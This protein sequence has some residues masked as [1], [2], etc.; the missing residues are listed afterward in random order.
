MGSACYGRLSDDLR[1]KLQFATL[2]TSG[3]YEG[4]KATILNRREGTVDQAVFR[5]SDVLGVKQVSNPNFPK[6]IIPYAWT[7]DG[8]TEWYVYHP[9]QADYKQLGGAVE[10][11][12]SVF[13]A[14]ALEPT[15]ES[16]PTMEDSPELTL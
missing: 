12:C 2:G 4:I 13:Q 14:Q 16:V 1:V 3:K 10:E 5:F 7:Y 15:Q 6:G 11:Y 8:K 9:S